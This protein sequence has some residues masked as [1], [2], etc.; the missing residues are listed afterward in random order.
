MEALQT[1]V[2]RFMA[3][4]GLCL[5]AIFSLVKS[6]DFD[7]PVA[8]ETVT[9][10]EVLAEQ[11][12]R[13]VEE[14]LERAAPDPAA[15]PIP[16]EEPGPQEG[17][18]PEPLPPE[19]QVGFSLEFASASSLET[20]I[21]GGDV[22]LLV[23]NGREYWAWS[24]RDGFMK[25]TAPPRYYQMNPKTVPARY[26]NSLM[27]SPAIV[28]GIWGVVLPSSISEQ[29]AALIENN[30]GGVLVISARGAVRLEGAGG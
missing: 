26:R 27:A 5:A 11:P 19:E 18:P 7:P 4:L 12:E 16:Q 21:E 14:L 25:A 15:Q 24:G 20:L 3:I 28:G 8:V 17:P 9:A 13:Q 30:T 29:I 23:S 1:D 6:P 22:S 2:M 10:L